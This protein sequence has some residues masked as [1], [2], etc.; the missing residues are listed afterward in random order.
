VIGELEGEELSVNVGRFGP[1]IKMGDQF[2]SIPKGEDLFEIDIERAKQLIEEKN[3]ADAPVGFFNELPVTKGKGRFG[4]FIKWDGIYINVP[5]RYNFDNLSQVEI[6][7]L[8]ET[9]I[10]KEANRY[11]QNWPTE[12]ISLENGRWG[13]YI[14]FGKKMLKVTKKL[15]DTKYA[16]E[17]LAVVPIEEVKR[18]IELQVPDA[19]AKKTKAPAKKSATKKTAP[20]KAAKKKV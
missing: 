20:K 1:Y 6:N 9:K 11:I 12:K 3:Q 13:P 5:R 16:T 18:M 14:K 7:E 2:I 19:F 10:T 17:E 4:P 15:D 8:V